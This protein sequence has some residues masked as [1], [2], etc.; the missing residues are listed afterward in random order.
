MSGLHLTADV[1]I[2]EDQ[3]HQ[4]RRRT[5]QRI[6]L[7][8]MALAGPFGSGPP[9]NAT[10]GDEASSLVPHLARQRIGRAG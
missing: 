3:D 2:A 4:R 1:Q 6:S 10:A 8:L 7:M 9:G 5:V